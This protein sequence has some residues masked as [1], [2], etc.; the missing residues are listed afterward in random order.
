MTNVIEG[1]KFVDKDYK[2]RYGNMQY[3]VEETYVHEGELI[4]CESGFHFSLTIADAI[5]W[6]P[7]AIL[8]KV[9]GAECI[10]D[11]RKFVCRKLEILEEV[12]LTLEIQNQ[13]AGDPDRDVRRGL[14]G[15]PN[16]L[17]EVRELLKKEKGN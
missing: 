6:N 3:A 9:R 16:L 11:Y 12:E 4:P 8:L 15:N 5:V 13:L 7:N 14:A 10:E 1:Y 17:P 2:S